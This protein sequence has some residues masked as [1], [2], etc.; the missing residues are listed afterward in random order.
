MLQ[1]VSP[2][3]VN[4]HQLLLDSVHI[5]IGMPRNRQQGIAIELILR[6]GE[7]IVMVVV[8]YQLLMWVADPILIV[9]GVKGIIHHFHDQT[10]KL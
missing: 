3:R 5:S 9:V 6:S 7:D 10:L 8:L 2:T 1:A 4:Q